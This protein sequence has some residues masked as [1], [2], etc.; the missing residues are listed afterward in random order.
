MSYRRF[1]LVDRVPVRVD[2]SERVLEQDVALTKLD[3][4]AIVR[5]WFHGFADHIEPARVF[6]TIMY[7][8][9]LR[10]FPPGDPRNDRPRIRTTSWK[11]AE[12]AHAREVEK[13]KSLEPKR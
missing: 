3:N 13:A 5:T 10:D 4:G 11:A 1:K 6:E 2:P 9:G 8:E 12:R 7:L